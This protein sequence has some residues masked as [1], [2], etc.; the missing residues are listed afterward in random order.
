MPEQEVRYIAE[1]MFSN[2]T[3]VIAID[4]RLESY[5]KFVK[6]NSDAAKRYMDSVREIE[7]LRQ[8]Q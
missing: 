4:D 3:G 7:A 6:N 5:I 2:D 8:V 1:H